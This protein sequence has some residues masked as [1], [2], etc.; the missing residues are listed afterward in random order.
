MSVSVNGIYYDHIID[1][2]FS[3]SKTVSLPE[4]I[5]DSIPD[6]DTNV[7]NREVIKITYVM[8]VTDAEK[9]TLDQLLINHAFIS[10][11]DD[12]YEKKAIVWVKSIEAVWEGNINWNDPWRITLTLITEALYVELVELGINDWAYFKNKGEIWFNEESGGYIGYP[13]YI[14]DPFS[15]QGGGYFNR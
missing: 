11:V 8:R 4:W 5:N 15:E 7:W 12:I 13:I 2:E 10:L 14:T 1:V 9:W 3:E 6:I